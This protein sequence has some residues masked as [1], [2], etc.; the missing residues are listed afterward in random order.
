MILRPEL[1]AGIIRV[2]EAC[3]RCRS[4]CYFQVR[5]ALQY[6]RFYYIPVGSNFQRRL[7][8]ARTL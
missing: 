5:T 7:P 8:G 4:P 1:V 2:L 6:M 3:I